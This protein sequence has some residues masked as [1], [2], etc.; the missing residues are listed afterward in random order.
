MPKLE[1]ADVV[2][3]FQQTEHLRGMLCREFHTVLIDLT[4]ESDAILDHM[5]RGTRYEIR[6]ALS[7]DDLT[8]HHWDG[9][10]RG[11]FNEFCGYAETFLQQKGQPKLD[12]AWISLM[13]DAGLLSLTR[14]DDNKANGLVWHAYHHGPER[15]TLLYSASSFR[16]NPSAEFRNLA[17]RAN[18]L[19][20][21]LDMLHFKKDGVA[22]YDF[23]GW[24]HGSTDEE[25]LRINKFKQQFGGKVVKN[26]ICEEARTLKGKLFLKLRS[27]LL[28]EAI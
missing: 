15:V 20:H 8:H 23:G 4:Q 14:I 26:Y 1:G 24:Y 21:W 11:I 6:R 25:R 19:H 7:A 13:A 9:R 2:R 10:E 27:A 28:G 16:E 3:R 18:R 5:K 12:R 22:T 17:G